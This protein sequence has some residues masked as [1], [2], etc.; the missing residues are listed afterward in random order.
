M[1]NYGYR[2]RTTAKYWFITLASILLHVVNG[3]KL[4]QKF[5]FEF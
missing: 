5:N 2:V 3:H 4:K 1:G